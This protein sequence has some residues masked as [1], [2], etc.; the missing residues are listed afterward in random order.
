MNHHMSR[1]FISSPLGFQGEK[2]RDCWWCF[3]SLWSPLC[4]EDVGRN[5][6][7]LQPQWCRYS[8]L[9]FPDHK[10]SGWR[11]RQGFGFGQRRYLQNLL[12]NFSRLLWEFVW[13][14]ATSTLKG[15]GCENRARFHPIQSFNATPNLCLDELGSIIESFRRNMEFDPRSCSGIVRIIKSPT[16]K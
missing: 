9:L 6:N 11:A 3:E 15:W 7:L 1:T 14:K 4:E 5:F 16:C 13:S 12:W 8:W 10:G 2:R